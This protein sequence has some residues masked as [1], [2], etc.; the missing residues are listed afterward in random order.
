MA[1]PWFICIRAVRADFVNGY[2]LDENLR[3]FAGSRFGN[4]PGFWFYFQILATGLLPWTGLLV[5]RLVDDIRAV[6]RGERLDGVE[7]LLWSWTLAVVGFFTVSTFKLDHYVFPAAPALC[8]LCAR[9]WT[10]VRADQWSPRHRAARVGLHLIGPFLVVVGVG[11][12]YFLIARLALPASA[13]IVPI[14]LVTAGA[15]L[16]A[17]TNVRGAL[18]P[19][20]PWLVMIALAITYAGLIGFVLPALEQRKVVPD[21]AQWVASRAQPD[22]RV[23]SYR[24][25]R[26][27]PAYRFYVGRHT[28]FLEDA[29]EAAAFFKTAEPFY[30]V[31]RRSAYD[32]FAAQ[33]IPLRVVYER[34]GMWATS[35][36]ALWRSYTPLTHFVVVTQAR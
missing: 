3:L 28:V 23:A 19:R 30:C 12:G 18:P 33:G 6:R 29:A 16:T 8:L 14:A 21:L 31:M 15:A 4:Q 2:V 9:A 24:L 27:N 34:E 35:G 11:C 20:V 17:L 36:R 13:V 26:W 32:E 22:D 10:D 1:A 7:I 5:G 25:N